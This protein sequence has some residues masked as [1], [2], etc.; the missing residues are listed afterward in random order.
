MKTFIITKKENV[1]SYRES[2]KIKAK[3]L[4]SA[5]RKASSMQF[6]KKTVLTIESESG[7]LLATKVNGKW[8][9]EL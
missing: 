8:V 4:S 6:F 5:K 2:D 1:N 7:I 3:N 9:N